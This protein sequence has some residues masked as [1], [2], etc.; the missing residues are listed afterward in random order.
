MYRCRFIHGPSGKCVPL[1]V[2][3]NVRLASK[4]WKHISSAHRWQYYTRIEEHLL[5]SQNFATFFRSGSNW[6]S[7]SYGKCFRFIYN[8]YMIYV[9]I[10]VRYDDIVN[11]EFGISD[12]LMYSDRILWSFIHTDSDERNIF[13]TDDYLYR[14]RWMFQHLHWCSLRLFQSSLKPYSYAFILCNTSPTH[15][16]TYPI[17]YSDMQNAVSIV[18]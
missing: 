13:F 11:V 6:I 2:I 8:T 15:I 4:I 17:Q 12:Y 7:L 9:C 18:I 1:L 10:C 5:F 3:E 16:C 14:N